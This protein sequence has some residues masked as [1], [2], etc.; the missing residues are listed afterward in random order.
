MRFGFSVMAAALLSSVRGFLGGA[1]AS[2][3]PEIA[4]PAPHRHRS[5]SKR[6]RLGGRTYKPNGAR[7]VDR[8]QRQIAEGRLTA[9]NGVV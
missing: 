4:A 6:I 7:E 8:R 5:A 2:P 9:S 3:F 1:I